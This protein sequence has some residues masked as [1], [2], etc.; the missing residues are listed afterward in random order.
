MRISIH[1]V[2]DYLRER[3]STCLPVPLVSQASDHTCWAAC[4]KMV[5]EW[6]GRKRDH[7]AY[8]HLQTS[9][10]STCWRPEGKCNQSRACS[11]ILGDWRKLGYTSTTHQLK[12]LTTG[13]I[14]KQIKRGRPV[15]AYLSYTGSTEGHFFL[16]IGTSTTRYT[17]DTSLII[18][19][20][21]RDH[22]VEM[23]WSEL[24]QWGHWQQTWI[25]A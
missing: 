25:V 17:A 3:F 8:I 16:V 4:Y 10:C 23:D 22:I 19:D 7:C 18:A 9:A 12:S 5:D 14:R 1:L 20:P 24:T 13:Q 21:L 2:V 15:E 6:R 11:L